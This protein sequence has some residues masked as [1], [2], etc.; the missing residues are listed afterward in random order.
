MPAYFQ[1]IVARRHLPNAN[2]HCRLAYLLSK[3]QKI[4]TS[5]KKSDKKVDNKKISFNKN[6]R[7][8]YK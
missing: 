5:K 6:F 7:I 1:Q 3:M 4:M 8:N 2:S